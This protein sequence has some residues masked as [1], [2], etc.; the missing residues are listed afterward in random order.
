VVISGVGPVD[1]NGNLTVNPQTTT[2]YVCVAT[3]SNPALPPASANLTET[4]N[5]AGSTPTGSGT[6]NVT[7]DLT[8]QTTP[9][10]VCQTIY[11]T[12][13]LNLGQAE[14]DTNQPI[15][16]VITSENIQAAVLTPAPASPTG[17]VQLSS[18]FGDYFFD[19]TATDSTGKALKARVDLQFVKTSIR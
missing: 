12:D 19:I 3:S 10:T 14:A 6:C 13:Y 11:R 2:T 7:F 8:G 4:V 9:L 5:S 15:G 18:T 1:V 16:F 17:T